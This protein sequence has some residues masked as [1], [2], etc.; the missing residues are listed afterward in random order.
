MINYITY[1]KDIIGNNYLGIKIENSTADPFLDQLKD[2]LGDEYEEYTNYQ[3]QRDKGS[4]HMTVINVMDY[5]RLSKEI[6]I[7]KFVNSLDSIF[8]YPIDDIK[9]MGIGTAERNGNRAYFIVCQSDKLDAVRTRYDL[10]KHDFHVTLGF[11]HKDVFGVPKNLVM[12]KESRFLQLLRQEFLKR[13]NFQFLKKIK[14]WDE[15]PDDDIIPISISDDF[16]KIKVRDY[17]MD[18][19]LSE[20]GELSIFTKYKDEDDLK[21]IPTTEIINILKK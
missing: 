21:R 18:I 3:K 8:K 2:I 6:G 13:E 7:D 15:S 1:L 16:L 19:G 9:F 20:S 4:Y 12:K 17:V 5:N 14:N 11:K 10:P